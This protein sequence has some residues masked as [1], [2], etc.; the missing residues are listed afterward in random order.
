[1]CVKRDK[2]CSCS[3]L[4]CKG[5][6]M[7]HRGDNVCLCVCVERERERDRSFIVVRIQGLKYTLQGR[8]RRGL[9]VFFSLCF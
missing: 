1:M 4:V 6:S 3:Y 9:F 2:G 8:Y 5:K 7:S